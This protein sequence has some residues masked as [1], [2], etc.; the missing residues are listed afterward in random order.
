[1]RSRATRRIVSTTVTALVAVGLTGF[2]LGSAEA[3][4]APEP[5]CQTIHP[6]SKSAADV[7]AAVDKLTSCLDGQLQR[8]AW[9]P[10]RRVRCPAG[11]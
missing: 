4:Q 6:A 11:V 1:M 10:S 2:G 7:R 5:V 3:L 9:Q 8:P